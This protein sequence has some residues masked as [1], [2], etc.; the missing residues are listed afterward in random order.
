MVVRKRAG[1][2]RGNGV[3][4]Y[5]QVYDLLLERIATG[6]SKPGSKLPTE[7]DLAKSLKVSS[8]TCRRALQELAAEGYI[9]PTAA[10]M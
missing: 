1:I 5:R 4:L 9:I 3:P 6:E 10:D 2:R 7:I 8:I